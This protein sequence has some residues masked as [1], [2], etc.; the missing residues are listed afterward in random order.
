MSES[1]NGPIPG[2]SLTTTPNNF[3]W[4]RPPET[5]K[6]EEALL[7]HVSR[8]ADEDFIDGATTLMELD[9]PIEILTNTVITNAVG[10][11]IHTVDV[12]LII[13]PA[14]HKELIS[15]AKNTGIDYKEFFSDDI[16]K[17]AREKAK[18]KTLVLH[19]MKKKMNKDKPSII[20]ETSEALGSADVE[21]FEDMR[22]E[23]E[24]G[25]PVEEISQEVLPEDALP[26]ELGTGLMSRGA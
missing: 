26:E 9:V 8:M 22:D 21:S 3:P 7:Y 24:G 1:L 20:S 14:V 15:L 19:K 25:P 6:P 4:E 18:L 2:Q 23:K 5:E 17:E 13:A 12:G 10:E 16:E 11:G